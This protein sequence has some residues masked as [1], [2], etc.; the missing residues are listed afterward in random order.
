MPGSKGN[1]NAK[2]CKT[3]GR[4]RST[5]NT[6]EELKILGEEM[7]AW[8]KLNNPLML[9]EWYIQQKNI[10]RK[11]WALLIDRIEFAQ[12]Y[13]VAID[14]VRK[15]Y[16]NGTIHN[17]IAQRFLRLYFP[18]LAKQEDKDHAEKIERE[19]ATKAKY[20]ASLMTEAQMQAMQAIEPLIKQLEINQAQSIERRT[21]L[22]TNSNESQS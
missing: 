18:E 17:S 8:V 6:P 3:S 4:P 12:Y 11:E 1:Q 16:I 19:E 15:N 2:G 9:S 21:V 14:I 13:E 22:I 5:H 20:A 7:I 10:L